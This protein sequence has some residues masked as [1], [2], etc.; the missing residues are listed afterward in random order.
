[1]VWNIIIEV[2]KGLLVGLSTAAVGYIKALPDGE[3]FE[4]VKAA[5]ALIIGGIAGVIAG[6]AHIGLN[7]AMEL[8][9]AFG[10]V[11]F[12]NAM[13]VALMKKRNASKKR[14]VSAKKK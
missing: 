5:P 14:V 3:D 9:A 11:T 8:V 10:M 6:I 4:W 7:S 1:M 13:W 12:V 2:G